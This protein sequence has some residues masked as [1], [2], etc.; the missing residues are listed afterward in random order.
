MVNYNRFAVGMRKEMTNCLCL[1]HIGKS[2]D[3]HHIFIGKE[4]P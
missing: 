4:M 2:G 3:I 1:G